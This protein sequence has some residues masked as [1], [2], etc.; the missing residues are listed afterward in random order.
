MR[1]SR[2]RQFCFVQKVNCF[3]KVSLRLVMFLSL[4]IFNMFYGYT[5]NCLFQVYQVYLYIIVSI[6]NFVVYHTDFS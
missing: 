1:I 3:K 2:Y 5:V 6:K 4:L